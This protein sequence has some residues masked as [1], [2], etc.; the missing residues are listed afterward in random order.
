MLV[1]LESLENYRDLK[2]ERIFF[3]ILKNVSLVS[4]SGHMEMT[5]TRH[6]GVYI[7]DNGRDIHKHQ[8][9]SHRRSQI[10][11]SF[12]GHECVCSQRHS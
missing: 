12:K 9:R 10:Y 5:K 2:I 4:G 11:A 6:R 3:R 8:K 1:K 7:L